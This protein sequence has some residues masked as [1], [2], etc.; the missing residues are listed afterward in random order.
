MGQRR[1]AEQR[2][3]RGQPGIAGAHAVAAP[4][5]EM[6]EEPGDQRGVQIGDIQR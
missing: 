6:I 2:V 5:L 1:E 4:G 3:D